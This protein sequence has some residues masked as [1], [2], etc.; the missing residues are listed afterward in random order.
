[1]DYFSD[2]SKLYGLTSHIAVYRI[3]FEEFYFRNRI[4]LYII[5]NL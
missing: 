5:G 1:M 4:L 3:F 2:I